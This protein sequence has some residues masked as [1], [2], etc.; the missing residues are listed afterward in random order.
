MNTPPPG[1]YNRLCY[2]VNSAP[3]PKSH[4]DIAARSIRDEEGSSKC[5]D[6]MCREWPS[7]ANN[8]A[9]VLKSQHRTDPSMDAETNLV[10]SACTATTAPAW[11]R[12]AWAPERLR[13]SESARPQLEGAAIGLLWLQRLT[14]GATA[15]GVALDDAV[16]AARAQQP[17]A[18][19][20]IVV[21]ERRAVVA[22]VDAADRP[23]VRIL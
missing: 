10:S 13:E 7:S 23:F 2:Y 11:P 20:G 6:V 3:C 17:A 19:P 5:K 15:H 9:P 22:E 4:D 12:S 1:G 21:V 14:V 16:G 8:C 18:R